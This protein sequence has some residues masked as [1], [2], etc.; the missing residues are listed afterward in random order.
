MMG[1][2]PLGLWIWGDPLP[3]DLVDG[4]AGFGDGLSGGLTDWMRDQ[5]GTNGS[6]NKCSPNYSNSHTAG[7]GSSLGLGAGRL[8]YAGLAKG[9]SMTASS[10]TAAS[11]FRSQLRGYFGGGKSL[12]PP[13]L[14]KYPTDDLLRE[15]AGRTNPYANAMGAGAAGMGANG[16]AGDDGCGCSQ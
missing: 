11:A 8:V 12:R 10:G 3:Q 14:S 6:V 4:A 7:A 13:N 9:Y 5:M 2:D 16:L 15:A 1:I